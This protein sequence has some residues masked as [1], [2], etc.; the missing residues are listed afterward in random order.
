MTA[1]VGRGFWPLIALGTVLVA[2]GAASLGFALANR[3]YEEPAAGWT[4]YVPLADSAFR[5]RGGCVGCTDPMPWLAA[6][7]AL[8]LAGI[9]PFAVAARRR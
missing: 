1:S 8:L 7:I 2:L 6:G 3:G 9:A 5:V 4:N